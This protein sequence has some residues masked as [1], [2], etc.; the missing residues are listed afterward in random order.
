[1]QTTR[2]RSNS[3]GG[4]HRRRSPSPTFTAPQRSC[5]DSA[6]DDSSQIYLI[7]TPDNRVS[8]AAKL[9]RWAMD[10]AGN[11]YAAME[12]KSI[13]AKLRAADPSAGAFTRE[14]A[15]ELEE[16][17]LD[18]ILDE[19]QKAQTLT[20]P[21]PAWSARSC[22]Q[23]TTATSVSK[24]TT[25][26][27]PSS[28]S[29]DARGGTHGVILNVFNQAIRTLSRFHASGWM[30]GDIK[31]ENLMFDENGALVVIDY[32]N[33]GPYRVYRRGWT[34][35]MVSYDWVPPEADR[36]RWE[37]DGPGGDLWALGCNLIRAFALRDGVEDGLIR[38][39]LWGGGRG[40]FWIRC[41][42][43][44]AQGETGAHVP[45]D[46]YFAP[47]S[48]KDTAPAG[49]VAGMPWDIFAFTVDLDPSSMMRWPTTILIPPHLSARVEA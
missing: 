27:K 33:A 45:A 39:T 19:V 18:D 21:A 30:H 34:G 29:P 49:G 23:K 13:E 43:C 12:I 15:R 24:R 26:K 40:A 11:F 7:T 8:S 48:I 10:S 6:V 9:R 25:P 2:R 31:L 1:M 32:E 16:T 3:S 41:R 28:S 35:A 42:G 22:A 36:G 5:I 44:E 17:Y 47:Q 20:R 4:D 14:L 46:D 37:E 38:E